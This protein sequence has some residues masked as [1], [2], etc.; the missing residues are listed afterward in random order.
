MPEKLMQSRQNGGQQ[1]NDGRR[2][3]RQIA[4]IQESETVHLASP[5][6]NYGSYLASS[7]W[8]LASWSLSYFSADRVN[9][10]LDVFFFL[11]LPSLFFFP[12][13]MK[14]TLYT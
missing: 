12:T 10:Y 4:G 3:A 9:Q 7:P 13:S 11:F 5:V 1:R 2:I 8:Q 6:L 14:H